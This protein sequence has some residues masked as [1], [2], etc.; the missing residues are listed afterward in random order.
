MIPSAE[1]LAALFGKHNVTP[2]RRRTGE[3]LRHT[4]P[5]GGCPLFVAA[6]DAGMKPSGG[7]ERVS[8]SG[9]TAVLSWHGW[10]KAEV[11]GVVT[12]FDQ[13]GLDIPAYVARYARLYSTTEQMQQWQH[14]MEV[15]Q[16][17]AKI[18]FGEASA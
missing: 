5:L 18:V 13:Q 12:G 4:G 9:L 2:V 11:E 6:L 16:A 17:V 14:G 10:E 7:C 8:T 1:E 3:R 15:G